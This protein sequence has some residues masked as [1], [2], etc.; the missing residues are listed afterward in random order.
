MS[1]PLDDLADL[2]PLLLGRVDPG[3]VVGAGVEEEDAL[4]GRG[5]E[6][7]LEVVK[8]EADRLLVVVRVGLYFEAAVL[9]DGDV[10]AP[11]W[12]GKVDRLGLGVEAR[13]ESATD[14]K[15]A[16]SRDGLGD[17]DL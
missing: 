15:R 3:R 1:L 4:V 12:G 14:A 10:V 17:R 7:G 5:L 6:V 8:V 2:L 9:E 16:S 11:G 13:K